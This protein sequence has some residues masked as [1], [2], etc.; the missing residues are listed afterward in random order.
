MRDQSNSKKT[1]TRHKTN[2]CEDDDVGDAIQTSEMPPRVPGWYK[3]L[4]PE[5]FSLNLFFFFLSSICAF[6]SGERSDS[7]Y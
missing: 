5:L 4:S 6:V 2:D 7:F 3:L 1:N